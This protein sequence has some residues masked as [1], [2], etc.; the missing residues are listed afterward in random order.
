M[1]YYSYLNMGVAYDN[2]NNFFNAI[3]AYETA[4]SREH[5]LLKGLNNIAVTLTQ[6]GM[7]KEALFKLNRSI[8]YHENGKIERDKEIWKDYTNRAKLLRILGKEN[9]MQNDIQK[10]FQLNPE[11]AN[12][13]FEF[14]RLRV[15][16]G[17]F[18][19]AE[20]AFTKAINLEPSKIYVWT[21]RG[22]FY[23]LIGQYEKAIADFVK[24]NELSTKKRITL[25]NLGMSFFL[26]GNIQKANECYIQCINKGE[27]FPQFDEFSYQYGIVL[28]V[29][30]V[31]G[32]G[33]IL[34]S[35]FFNDY[36]RIYFKI[37]DCFTIPNKGERVK[38]KCCYQ[39]HK[40]QYTPS[41]KHIRVDN[42][43]T[44][45]R[46]KKSKV[47]HAIISIKQNA[48]KSSDEC[49]YI[50]IFYPNRT[51]LPFS[52]VENKLDIVTIEQLNKVGYSFV[53]LMVN[54]SDSNIVELD[55]IKP[56]KLNNTYN[57]KVVS[58]R[59]KY[60]GMDEW[61]GTDGCPWDPT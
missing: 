15:H 50:E 58:T 17:E 26:S 37:S 32:F 42:T 49:K 61:C 59:R 28:F 6:I 8:S 7:Q 3:Q 27:N 51:I 1:A 12:S 33:F 11:W 44:D 29:D 38:F 54:I 53:E 57:C 46:F 47:Y 30:K 2:E 14:A 34:G 20:E 45:H 35:T 24:A 60:S 39:M 41:A 23:E 22:K 16:K 19:Y 56:I 5:C 48:F 18:N 13:W 25:Y 9:D 55:Y 43:I 36:D 52:L 21:T 31:K 40:M 4:I 10:S